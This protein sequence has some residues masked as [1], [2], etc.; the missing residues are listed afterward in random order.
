MELL[1]PILIPES[2]LCRSRSPNPCV[3]NLQNAQARCAGKTL[4]QNGLKLKW[5]SLVVI[6][7][8]AKGHAIAKHGKSNNSCTGLCGVFLL[9]A[10]PLRAEGDGYI[11]SVRNELPTPHIRTR[12]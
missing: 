1:D 2:L 10:K 8:V 11:I 4:L 5:I 7:P 12:R 3:D 6:S 9:P